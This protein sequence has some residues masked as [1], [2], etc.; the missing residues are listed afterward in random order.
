MRFVRQDVDGA[1]V[2]ASF[3]SGVWIG[4]SVGIQ[5][6]RYG[7]EWKIFGDGTIYACVRERQGNCVR[8]C[9]RVHLCLRE[10]VRVGVCLCVC[11][12]VLQDV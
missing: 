9:A 6:M 1:K 8:V 10:R 5:N 3:P 11:V 7:T 2:M 4:R 12:C